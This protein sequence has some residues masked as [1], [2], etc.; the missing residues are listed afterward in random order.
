MGLGKHCL[1]S[2]HDDPPVPEEVRNIGVVERVI[3]DHQARK[4]SP[5]SFVPIFVMGGAY[6][7]AAPDS[8]AFGGRRDIGYV[9][10]ISATSPTVEGFAAE[11]EWSREYWA[12][13]LPHAAGSGGYI[14]FLAEAD[15]AR[16]AATYGDK[17]DRLRQ[18]KTTYDRTTSSTST[19]TSAPH[20]RP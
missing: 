12:A 10:N 11:R 3:L 7:A 17:L 1:V 15:D 20:N 16:V 18:I 19:P 13:L 6:A 8:N 4:V 9:V 14:N 2:G 5:L